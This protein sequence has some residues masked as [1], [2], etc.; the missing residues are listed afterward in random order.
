MKTL[1]NIIR[2]IEKENEKERRNKERE[3]DFEEII[4]KIYNND[5]TY[6]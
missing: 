2:D 6:A 3:T 5:A 1:D 4:S